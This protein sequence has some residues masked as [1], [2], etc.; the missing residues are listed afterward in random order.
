MG[1]V[2]ML[3]VLG[4]MMVSNGPRQQDQNPS[5]MSGSRTG[6]VSTSADF[7]QEEIGFRSAPDKPDCEKKYPLP[8]NYQ[9]WT[10]CKA[11]GGGS[12]CGGPEQ[13]ACLESERLVTFTCD[14]GTYHQCYGERGN[15]CRGN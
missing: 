6:L 14:Q 10:N 12:S 15:G 7:L 13:C 2:F 4:S 8:S 1:R 11:N 3:L 9:R 5:N